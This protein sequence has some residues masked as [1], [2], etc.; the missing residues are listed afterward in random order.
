[1]LFALLNGEHKCYLREV[2]M[3]K[4]I[5]AECLWYHEDHDL[6][7]EHFYGFCNKRDRRTEPTNT[8]CESLRAWHIPERIS[9]FNQESML[10]PVK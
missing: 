9:L 2:R 3:P 1:M 10:F 4:G 5:C 6:A 8:A 7:M